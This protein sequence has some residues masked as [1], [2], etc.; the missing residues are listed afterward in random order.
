MKALNKIFVVLFLSAAVMSCDDDESGSTVD[1]GTIAS[2]YYEEG[3]ETSIVIPFRNSNGSITAE[4]ITVDGTATEGV[5]YEIGAVTEEGVS[6]T[7]LDDD[8][9]EL[10]ETI[11]LAI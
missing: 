10:A 5:D 3:G 7:L 8:E 1:F 9:A 11:R 6:I 2:T 4:D